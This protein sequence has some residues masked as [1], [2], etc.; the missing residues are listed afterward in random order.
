M[1]LFIL[2]NHYTILTSIVNLTLLKE[3]RNL[4]K[5]NINSKLHIMQFAQIQKNRANWKFSNL[6][7]NHKEI[8]F[9]RK[10][11]IKVRVMKKEQ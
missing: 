11:L 1:N 7:T 9:I 2:V 8:Y 10:K 6:L 4:F 3:H 5:I